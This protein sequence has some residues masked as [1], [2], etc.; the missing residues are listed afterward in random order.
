MKRYITLSFLSFLFAFS[1]KAQQ[2]FLMYNMLD[3]PQSGYSNPSNQFNGSFYIGLPGISSNYYSISNSGFAYSD[4]VKKDGDSLLLDF[5][6]LLNEL[7][8]ENFTSF[9]TKIDLFSLGISLSK[10]TQLTLNVTENVNFRFNYT[11]DFMAF[12]YEGNAAFDDNTANFENLGISLNHYREYGIGI[13]HQLTNKLRLGARAKYLYGMEN[14]YSKKS[15]IRLTTDPETF[16]LTAQ[17]DIDIQTAGIEDVDIDE[18]GESKYLFGRDN[19]GFGL[20]LGGHYEVNDRLSL[21]ASVIDLGFINWKSYT[22]SYRVENGEYSYSGIEVNAFTGQTDTVSG[23]TSFDRILDSLEEAFDLKEPTDGYTTP[24]T[25]RI[26]IGANYKLGQRTV[27]G[28]LL[29]TEVFQRSIRPS[30]T[31]SAHRKMTKW[32]SLATSYTVINRSYNNLGFGVSLNPGPVQFYVMSDNILSAFQP[33]HARHAQ[34]RFGINLIFGSK[35][36]KEM[37]P[38]FETRSEL[39]EQKKKK[40]EKKE[41]D[42]E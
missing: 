36:H 39:R 41:E 23:E 18:E 11:K 26:Y 29:Q 24:L 17:A 27:L 19:K 22:K 15:D 28:G 34:V 20:D 3:V 31:L 38:N 21:N 9:N 12:V 16:K 25:A 33:Q 37:H 35:K 30:L 1:V 7:E 40:K 2:D 13:S 42:S 14:V 10:R 4:A 32:I 8:D 5:R 6:S